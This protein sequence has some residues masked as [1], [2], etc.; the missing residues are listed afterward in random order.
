M[1][2]TKI[3]DFKY[4]KPSFFNSLLVHKKTSF[5]HKIYYRLIDFKLFYKHKKRLKYSIISLSGEII[6]FSFLILFTD[7]FGLFYLLSAFLSYLI[8]L[9]NNFFLNLRFT[10]KYRPINLFSHIIETATPPPNN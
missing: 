1:K 5:F 3:T 7:V 9:L 4:N 2:Q 6:D 8:A 10:F